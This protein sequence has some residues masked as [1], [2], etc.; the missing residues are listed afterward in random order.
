LHEVCE[1]IRAAGGQALGVACDVTDRAA[2]DGAVAEAV[3]EFGAIDVVVANAGFGVSGLFEALT[4]D[5][6]RRQFEIN[7]FGVVDTIYATLPHLIASRGRLGV[8][9]SILGRIGGPTTT[10]YC[11]S[12][13]AVAGLAE[14]IYYELAEHGVS[15]TCINPGIV[16]S[17]IRLVDNEHRCKEG[18]ND[19]APSWLRVPT[20]KACREILDALHRRKFEAVITGHGRLACFVARHFPRTVRFAVRQATKGKLDALGKRKRNL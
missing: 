12:K 7:V 2:L 15:V 6:F 17:N 11:A 18:R 8:V 3:R 9:S 19:P 13:F 1:A 5:D 4:T 10:A 20:A 16:E 14:S